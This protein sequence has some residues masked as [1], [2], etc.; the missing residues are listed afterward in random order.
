MSTTLGDEEE[1]GGDIIFSNISPPPPTPQPTATPQRSKKMIMKSNSNYQESRR[2]STVVND[3][4]DSNNASNNARPPRTAGMPNEDLDEMVDTVIEEY[5]DDNGNVN[6]RE[7]VKDSIQSGVEKVEQRI[8]NHYLANL[9]SYCIDKL[10]QCSLYNNA[11]ILCL[12]IAIIK[13]IG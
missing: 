7:I 6:T 12:S 10:V 9:V 13:L 2:I 3:Y 8:E 11:H 1:G 4:M 5:T